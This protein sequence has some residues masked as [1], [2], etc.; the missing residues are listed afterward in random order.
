[1]LTRVDMAA[2]SVPI[3]KSSPC[4]T[5]SSWLITHFSP[6][7]SEAGTPGL[8]Y[9]PLFNKAMDRLRNGTGT[10]VDYIESL[11]FYILRMS[12]FCYLH[13]STLAG[14]RMV[15]DFAKDEWGRPPRI[16]NKKTKKKRWRRRR[17]VEGVVCSEVGTGV[18]WSSSKLL[19][20]D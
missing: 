2:H 5:L 12:D 14:R 17:R 13:P 6:A 4:H 7:P 10:T 8:N 15:I 18:Y 3:F 1:M 11:L 20:S 16:K 9:W 19:E